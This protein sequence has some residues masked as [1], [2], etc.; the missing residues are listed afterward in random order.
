M[1]FSLSMA[2]A[3]YVLRIRAICA[4]C[5]ALLPSTRTPG[6]SSPPGLNAGLELR[7]TI[8]LPLSGLFPRRITCGCTDP[9][10]SRI[11]S[12]GT[13]ASIGGCSVVWVQPLA[14]TGRERGVCV[15][16]VVSTHAVGRETLPFWAKTG[17]ES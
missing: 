16:Y 17:V 6:C 8:H 2:D 5:C 4:V 13:A 1:L 3:E 9:G 14:Q 7:I 10:G 11:V 12:P 15:G